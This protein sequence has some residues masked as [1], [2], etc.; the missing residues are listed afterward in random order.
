MRPVAWPGL[1]CRSVIHCEHGCGGPWG[2]QV[3]SRLGFHRGLGAWSFHISRNGS[4]L[5]WPQSRKGP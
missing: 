3:G 1:G 2:G 4:R 5:G